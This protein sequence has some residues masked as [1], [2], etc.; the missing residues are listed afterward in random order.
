MYWG[1]IVLITL[2][3]FMLG[4]LTILICDYRDFKHHHLPKRWELYLTWKSNHKHNKN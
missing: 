1:Y 4:V 3:S 2:F